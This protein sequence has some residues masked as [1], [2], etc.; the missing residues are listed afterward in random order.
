MRPPSSM[1]RE[2]WNGGTR[3][4]ALTAELAQDSPARGARNLRPH[5]A[6]R[7]VFGVRFSGLVLWPERKGSNGREPD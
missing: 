1:P 5:A 6:H 3:C 2:R 7:P 4:G